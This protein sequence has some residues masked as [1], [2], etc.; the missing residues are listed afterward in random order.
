[1]LFTGEKAQA[2][3]SVVMLYRVLKSSDVPNISLACNPH[4]YPSCLNWETA[5]AGWTGKSIFK[6]FPPKSW[7]V[8]TIK[9]EGIKP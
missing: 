9:S 3:W 6:V 7:P 5:L 2:E 1:M 8:E 4:A